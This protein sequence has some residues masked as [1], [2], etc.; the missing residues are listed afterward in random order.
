MGCRGAKRRSTDRRLPLRQSCFCVSEFSSFIISTKLEKE[1]H[2]M[3]AEYGYIFS[4]IHFDVIF[5]H[6]LHKR[7]RTMSKYV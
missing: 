7:Q 4:Y 5:I 2:R 3:T 6:I 1:R